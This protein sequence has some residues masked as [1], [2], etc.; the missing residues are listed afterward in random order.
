MEYV[1][2]VETSHARTIHIFHSYAQEDLRFFKQLEKQLSV[3]KQQR[4][5]DHWHRYALNAGDNVRHVIKE[6]LQQSD[7]I[8]LLI[9]PDFIASEDCIDFEMLQAMQQYEKG[10]ASVVP[11]LLRPTL[12]QRLPC[13]RLWS[14]PPSPKGGVKPV[15]RWR[16]KDEAFFRIAS[17]LEKIIDGL[18]NYPPRAA[19]EH[20]RTIAQASRPLWNIPYSLHPSFFDRAH[21]LSRLHATFRANRP[22]QPLCQALSGP[23][24]SGKTQLALA[25]AYRYRDD[26]QAI[27]WLKADSDEQLATDFMS[28]AELLQLP[29]RIGE[30]QTATMAAIKRWFHNHDK[31]LVIFDNVGPSVPLKHFMPEGGLGDILITQQGQAALTTFCTQVE[32]DMLTPEEGAL[33]LLRRAQLLDIDAS[34]ELAPPELIKQACTLAQLLGGHPLALDQAGAYITE[35]KT[36]LTQYI[37]LYNEYNAQLSQPPGEF[38]TQQPASVITNFL[39][40]LQ[41]IQ[42]TNPA[43]L[44]LLRFCTFLHPDSIPEEIF[45]LGAPYLGPILQP[46]VSDTSTLDA[47]I[48]TLL[49]FSLVRRNSESGSLSLHRLIQTAFKET[50]EESERRLWAQRAVHAVNQAFPDVEFEQWPR[51]QFYLPHALNCATLIQQWQIASPEA[52]RLLNEAGLYL[53]EHGQYTATRPLYEQALTIRERVLGPEHPDTAQTLNNLGELARKLARDDEAEQYYT[54]AR[55]IREHTLGPEHPDTAQTLNNLGELAHTRGNYPVAETFYRQALAIRVQTLGRAHPDT[56]RSIGDLAGI[57]EEQGD[58]AQAEALYEEARTLSEDALGLA[59]PDTG[60]AQGKL[61]RFYRSQGKYAQAEAFFKQ[62]LTITERTLGSDHPDVAVLLNNLAV[63]Y[64]EIGN[65]VEAETLLQRAIRI[66]QQAFGPDHRNTAA[67]IRQ[68]ALCYSEQGYY[69]QAEPLFQQ[70]LAI[71]ERTSG[72]NHPA[73]AQVLTNLADLYAA[74]NSYA[75]AEPLYRRALSIYQQRLGPQHPDTVAVQATHLAVLDKLNKDDMD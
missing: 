57:R 25:Y 16:D 28:L 14:L 15:S 42:N 5:I 56:I 50:M 60:L 23:P 54:R 22:P 36:S 38:A 13:A 27:F 24:D 66:W 73:T 63:L 47:T 39:L 12:W 8:L 58:N 49:N 61:A 45:A 7:I 32:L 40:S 41:K 11:I 30:D 55:A 62:A 44:E 68:L 4:L 33:F 65:Y 71:R 19:T 1:M 37:Q 43:A 31:W 53:Y 64:R 69:A 2:L 3:L 10:K 67:S 48:K 72:R 26:Y 59:H 35:T 34:L 9:S 6:R 20:A 75:Q 52:G 21:L 74:Q 17:A 29:E 51:C 46:V 18:M 70:V